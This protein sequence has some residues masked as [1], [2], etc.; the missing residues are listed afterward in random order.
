M[1][2]ILLLCAILSLSGCKK[3]VPESVQEV[4]EPDFITYV[5]QPTWFDIGKVDINSNQYL[6]FTIVGKSKWYKDSLITIKE[7]KITPD[8]DGDCLPLTSKYLPIRVCGDTRVEMYSPRNQ[9]FDITTYRDRLTRAV[10][11]GEWMK[12]TVDNISPRYGSLPWCEEICFSK[13]KP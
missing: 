11:D 12:F 10:K 7:I 13:G 3:N 5:I 9:P 4:T 8:P 2:T 1:R 6:Q